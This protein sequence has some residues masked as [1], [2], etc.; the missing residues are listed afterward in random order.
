MRSRTTEGIREGTMKRCGALAHTGSM[1]YARIHAYLLSEYMRVC[2]AHS[3]MIRRVACCEANTTAHSATIP[4]PT[5]QL[6]PGRALLRRHAGA[7]NGLCCP[8]NATAKTPRSNSQNN[9]LKPLLTCPFLVCQCPCVRLFRAHAQPPNQRNVH[10][11]M[12]K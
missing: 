10:P 3:R 7:R 12:G 4:I 5:T 1:V 11:W 9:P 6:L 2:T 8:P